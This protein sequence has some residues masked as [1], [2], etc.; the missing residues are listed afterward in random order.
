MDMREHVAQQTIDATIAS[1]AS[2]TTY[3]GATLTLTGWLLTSEAAVLVGIVLGVAGF[4]VN[5]FYRHRADRRE[6]FEHDQRMRAL[7]S[8]ND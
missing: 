5:W 2:K 3:T 8:A 1:A 7:R 4:L 6:Q